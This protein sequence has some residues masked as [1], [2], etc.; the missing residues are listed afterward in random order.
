M[1]PSPL[2]R[3]PRLLSL[4]T[5]FAVSFAT[6]TAVVTVLVGVLSYNAAARLVRVL[7]DGAE[8]TVVAGDPNQAV[9]GYRGADPALLRGEEPA[10][11]LT[12]SHR[13]APAIAEAVTAIAGRL[14]GA[15]PGRRLAGAEE[16]PGSV[17]VR[18]AGAEQP[19]RAPDFNISG[20]GLVD[21][22]GQAQKP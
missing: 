6:V 22:G 2:G 14:P 17:H 11:T 20:V 19:C 4:R 9:F 16:A 8:L 10:I 18:I 21:T 5:T 1:G 7:S 3:R 12:Q 13:C 15:D